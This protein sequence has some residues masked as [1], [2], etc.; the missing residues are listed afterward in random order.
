MLHTVHKSPWDTNDLES[1]LRVAV[2]GD[3]LLLYEDAV[4]AAVSGSEWADKLIGLIKS[5]VAVTML[6]PDMVAR[7]VPSGRLAEGLQTTDY[8]GFVALVDKHTTTQAW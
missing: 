3:D 6:H 5:G 1:C 8:D 2:A 4:I 7:G